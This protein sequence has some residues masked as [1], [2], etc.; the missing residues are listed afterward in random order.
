MRAEILSIGNEVLSGRTLDTN[1]QFLARLLEDSGAPVVGHQTVPDDA[2]AIAAALRTGL[3]RA[4]LVVATGGLGPTPDDLT[5]KAVAQA[6]GRP[7]ILHPEILEA[8]HERWASWS[9]G[10]MPANNEQQ[11]LL[12]S[13]ATAWPNPVGSAPGIHLQHEGRDVVLL[14][15]VPDEMETLARQRL[16][17]LVRGKTDTTVEY[18]LLR[19]VGIAESVLEERLSDLGAR[20]PGA[21]LAYLP[22]LGGVDIRI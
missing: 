3:Q 11:A 7:L 12:P 8:I 6:L 13:G 17:P 19:T 15:G 1:F 21:S 18:C 20:L 9:R 22:G 14:P 2:R 10:P 5:V 16:G 4:E